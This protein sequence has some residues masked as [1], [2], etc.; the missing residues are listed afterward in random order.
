MRGYLFIEFDPIA[1]MRWKNI[2]RT[3]G[4]NRLLG[5]SLFPCRVRPEAMQI[6]FD[7]CDGSYLR[8]IYT[9]DEALADLAGKRIRITEGPLAG[10]LAKVSWSQGQ[11]VSVM[12]SFMGSHEV[13]LKRKSVEVV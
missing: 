7:A 5:S 12:L 9:V 11:R 2:Q 8:D 4:I 13:E 6:I 1:D 10:R 3:R